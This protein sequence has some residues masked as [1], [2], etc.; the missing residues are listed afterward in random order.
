MGTRQAGLHV[1]LTVALGVSF[2]G[3]LVGTSPGDYDLET[4]LTQSS[5]DLGDGGVPMARSYTQMLRTPRGGGSGWETDLAALRGPSRLDPVPLE[6][7][8]IAVDLAQRA[9]LR[10][11]D[12]APPR[13]PHA[14]RQ[15]SAAECLSCH[16]QGLRIRGRLAAPM[17]HRELTSCTQCHVT[18]EAPMPGGEPL[19]ADPRS[20]PNTFAGRLP[21]TAGPRAWE[22]APPQVPHTT[23]MRER[24]ES[25]HGV[26]GRD[27]LR[28]P[29][30]DRQSCEQCHASSAEA[31][32]R[33]GSGN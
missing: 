18:D 28:T 19:P 21:A 26:N 4:P 6:G 14:V 10:A 20:A 15:D 2:V 3:F 33:P 7:R 32:L 31:N 11:F 29:H 24:C 25:C 23:W 1:L 5:V 12:G 17:S 27:A 13:I 30:P 16:D 8:S 9:T 22:I